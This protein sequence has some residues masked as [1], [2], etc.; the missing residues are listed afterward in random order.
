[1]NKHGADD[2]DKEEQKKNDDG[3]N[4]GIQMMQGSYLNKIC[5]MEQSPAPLTERRL[6]VAERSQQF[7]LSYSSV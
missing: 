5:S 1:M 2:D 3:T 6:D 4:P 7:A